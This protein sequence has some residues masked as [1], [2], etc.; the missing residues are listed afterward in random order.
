MVTQNLAESREFAFKMVCSY[1]QG[2]STGFDK[3]FNF[4]LVNLSKRLLEWLHGVFLSVLR[5]VRISMAFNA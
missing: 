5:A 1:E 2:I 4:S 3:D